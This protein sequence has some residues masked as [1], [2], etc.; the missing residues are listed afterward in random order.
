MC[1]GLLFQCEVF[2]NKKDKNEFL[3]R[4]IVVIVNNTSVHSVNVFLVST[5]S[6]STRPAQL[7]ECIVLLMLR[8]HALYYYYY[9]TCRCGFVMMTNDRWLCKCLWRADLKT[10]SNTMNSCFLGECF[11]VWTHT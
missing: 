5:S 7:L 11:W 9:L 4:L 3:L 8:T 6:S 2:P 1:R 10:F